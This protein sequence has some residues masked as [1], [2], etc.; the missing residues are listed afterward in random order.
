MTM[1]VSLFVL[2]CAALA[3]IIALCP[4]AQAANTLQVCLGG[5]CRY[6]NLSSAINA[7]QPG[8]TIVV[9]A[10][11]YTEDSTARGTPDAQGGYYFLI[12][13]DLTINISGSV[14]ITFDTYRGYYWANGALTLVTNGDTLNI[15]TGHI[16]V[17]NGAVWNQNGDFLSYAPGVGGVNLQENSVW[18]QYGNYSLEGIA[19]GFQPNGIYCSLSTW[20]QYGDVKLGVANQSRGIFLKSDCK[21]VQ[22]GSVTIN[23][24]S[25]DEE[26][27]VYNSVWLQKG[28]VTIVASTASYQIDVEYGT[29]ASYGSVSATGNE[30]GFSVVYI[31]AITWNLYGSLT[32]TNIA[33]GATGVYIDLSILN[34][35]GELTVS[36]SS[37]VFM[38]DPGIWNQYGSASIVS[39]NYCVQ[40]NSGYGFAWNQ[41]GS[42]NLTVIDADEA[43]YISYGLWNQQGDT[44]I[45][46]PSEGSSNYHSTYAIYINYFS[47]WIQNGSVTITGS[48]SSTLIYLGGSDAT[49]QQ[50]G[51]VTLMTSPNTYGIYFNNAFWQQNGEVYIDASA[52]GS[53]AVYVYEMTV[54]NSNNNTFITLS[55]SSK[56]GVYVSRDSG[57]NLQYSPVFSGGIQSYIIQCNLNSIISGLPIGTSVNTD[58]SSPCEITYLPELTIGQ[59]QLMSFSSNGKTANFNVMATLSRPAALAFTAGALVSGSFAPLV[60]TSG[61][62]FSFAAGA[63]TATLNGNATF[64]NAVYYCGGSASLTVQPSGQYYVIGANNTFALSFPESTPSSAGKLVAATAAVASV[65]TRA[66]ANLI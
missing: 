7:S 8:D 1:T 19:S 51:T 58:S 57:W 65:V 4:A 48:Y 25:T 13:H 5:S 17:K 28:D 20:N 36:A 60:G 50:S 49:W 32:I 54:W 12:D 53:T 37:G 30:S 15:T 16:G 44:T 9:A 45:D 47:E 10:G 29:W 23:N 26:I 62:G 11:V 35:Y 33:E 64:T 21:W 61:K 2:L 31:Y 14:S 18:N 24:T 3:I 52:T 55:N 6:A 43:V 40:M 41:F 39:N 59:P 34:Q 38:N 22:Q 56:S 63:T 42:A 66:L 46:S 27:T